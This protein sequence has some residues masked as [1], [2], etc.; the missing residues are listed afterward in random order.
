MMKCEV[1]KVHFH[2]WTHGIVFNVIDHPHRQR[3]WA[4]ARTTF[5]RSEKVHDGG[6]QKAVAGNNPSPIV[7]IVKKSFFSVGSSCLLLVFIF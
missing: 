1:K 3:T 7:A 5:W 2:T 6:Q 4:A